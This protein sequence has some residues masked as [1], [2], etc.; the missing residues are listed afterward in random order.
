MSRFV[1]FV[2]K[3]NTPLPE[4]TSRALPELART[5]NS[6]P[7]PAHPLISASPPPAAW[8]AAADEPK[9]LEKP[10]GP[11]IPYPKACASAV[12]TPASA[13]AKTT[14]RIRARAR[15]MAHLV[16]HDENHLRMESFLVAIGRA[17]ALLNAVGIAS[18]LGGS[19]G[20]SG[21]VSN[22][23]RSIGV[24]QE[25]DAAAGSTLWRCLD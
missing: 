1:G 9:N 4:N 13:V 5:P 18:E 15:R 23:A 20:L 22:S 19:T 8:I 6:P 10:A 7:I 25:N 17:T 11:A 21:S 12:L 3:Y 16:P 14:S 2:E 24:A